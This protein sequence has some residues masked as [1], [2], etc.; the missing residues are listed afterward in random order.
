M[1]RQPFLPFLLRNRD[2]Q[3][4]V[5]THALRQRPALESLIANCIMAWPVAEA[6]MA[7]LLGHLLGARESEAY[8]AV[9]QSLRRSAGQR[10]AISEAAR[11][12]LDATDRELLDAI[13]NVHKSVESERTALSHGHFGTY[14]KLTDGIVW[15]DT[16]S[17][18]DV[19]TRLDAHA[20]LND[21]TLQQLYSQASFYKEKDLETIFNDIKMISNL[22]YQFIQYLRS[23]GP[24]RA[25][26]YPQLCDQPRIAQELVKLRREKNPPAQP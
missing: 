6:E 14:T 9:F 19:R 18:V 20:V 12:V 25:E 15:M 24:R 13:L 22:W 23:G 10:D 21:E 1:P 7:L 5:G 16:K 8:L 11:V 17:Y 26:L 4:N 3:F 2:G